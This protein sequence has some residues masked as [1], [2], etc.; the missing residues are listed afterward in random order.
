MDNG[1]KEA[2]R[3]YNEGKREGI[4]VFCDNG[5]ERTI[6]FTEGNTVEIDMGTA[7]IKPEYIPVQ[8]PGEICIDKEVDAGGKKVLITCVRIREPHAVCITDSTDDL[9]RIAS[10]LQKNPIFPQFVW[11]D[12]VRVIN[13]HEMEV[14]TYG[15][16]GELSHIGLCAALCAS[17]MKGKTGPLVFI[18][19]R[20]IQ[21]YWNKMNNRFYLKCNINSLLEGVENYGD[22]N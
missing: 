12:F 6:E 15:K 10:E 18:R 5:L 2:I 4:F 22:N 9:G 1:I 14:L 17:C 21:V 20:K 7:L 13:E 19:N 8:H 3:L 16:G 11:V